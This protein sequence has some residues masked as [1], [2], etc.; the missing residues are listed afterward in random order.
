MSKVIEL[1]ESD[2]DWDKFVPCDHCGHRSYY[3]VTLESG[4]ILNYCGHFYRANTDRLWE[5][6]VRVVVRRNP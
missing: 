6:A 4:S 5:V 1:P 3:E 2:A